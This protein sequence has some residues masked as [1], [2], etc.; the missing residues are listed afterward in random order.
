LLAFAGLWDRWRGPD[1]PL[2]TFAIITTDANDAMRPIHDRMP[3]I[4]EPGNHDAW[5]KSAG[6]NLLAPYRE[7]MT[8]YQISHQVNSPGNDSRE[9]IEEMVA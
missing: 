3:V 1:G 7:G 2:D 6:R 4:L 9:I 8:S 5:L